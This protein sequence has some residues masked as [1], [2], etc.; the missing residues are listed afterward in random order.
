MFIKKEDEFE[1][2]MNYYDSSNGN[3]YKKG[4]YNVMEYIN[5]SNADYISFKKYKKDSAGTIII[6]FGGDTINIDGV[7]TVEWSKIQEALTNGGKEYFDLTKFRKENKARLDNT[8][9]QL[10]PNN[11]EYRK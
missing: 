9:S 11:K 3:A 10:N 4:S 6:M 1:D 2:G 5:I 7:S 8:S